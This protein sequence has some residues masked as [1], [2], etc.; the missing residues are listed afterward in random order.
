MMHLMCPEPPLLLSPQMALG[1]FAILSQLTHNVII[2]LLAVP[3]HIC[4][5]Q[6]ELYAACFM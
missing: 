4:R 5:G 2:C 6:N 1:L 3:M